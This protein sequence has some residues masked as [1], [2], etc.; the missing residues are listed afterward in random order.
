MH[1]FT[2]R[3]P[4]RD[5]PISPCLQHLAWVTLESQKPA[6]INLQG[7]SG[8]ERT[9]C[10]LE[11][12]WAG[13]NLSARLL[14]NGARYEECAQVSPFISTLTAGHRHHLPFPNLPNAIPLVA[15]K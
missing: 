1:T 12:R 11:L 9:A 5:L 8:H 4:P 7:R 2:S 14:A 13:S 6:T 3:I 10:G 15:I